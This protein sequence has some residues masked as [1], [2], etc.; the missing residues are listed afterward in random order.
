MLRLLFLYLQVSRRYLLDQH[1]SYSQFT[2]YRTCPAAWRIKYPDG[3]KQQD[4]SI[5]LVFGTAIHNTIQEFLTL[6]YANPDKVKYFDLSGL[7]KEKLFQVFKDDT[8]ILEDGTKLY[9]TDKQT[10]MTFYLQGCEILRHVKRDMKTLFPTKHHILIGCEI[11]IKI[12]LSEFVH[13]EGHIDTIIKDTKSGEYFIYDYKTSSR[14]WFDEKKDPL[15]LRQVQLYK[16][17]YAEQLKID[18]DL[19]FVS[20]IILK[21]F[22]NE[23]SEW[24]AAKNRINKF[25]PP[26]SKITTRKAVAELQAF[27]DDVFDANG[28]YKADHLIATP[29]K[30]ACQYC[31]FKARKDLCAVGIE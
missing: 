8:I 29:S 11:P 5:F 24:P 4:Q 31:Q 25:E 9:P 1:L 20:F 17:Y 27:H 3:H 6:Y 12:Q 23:K 28:N 13:F 18:E 26:Q 30:K 16:K 14:G 15:K 19:V 7:L 22:I 2:L 10:L 21:R